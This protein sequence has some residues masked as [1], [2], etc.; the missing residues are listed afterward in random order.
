MEITAKSFEKLALELGAAA[1]DDTGQGHF[2]WVASASFCA[3]Q[4]TNDR[5]YL[6]DN[7]KSRERKRLSLRE[8]NEAS[9]RASLGSIAD[10]RKQEMLHIVTLRDIRFEKERLVGNGLKFSF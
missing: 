4:H 6:F 3:M 9:E 7:E 10:Y 8:T 2:V 5:L 1:T